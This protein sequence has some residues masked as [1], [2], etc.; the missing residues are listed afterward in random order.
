MFISGPCLTENL[1]EGLNV[2][3]SFVDLLLKIK[4]LRVVSL[5]SVPT[6]DPAEI[7]QKHKMTHCNKA[8]L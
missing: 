5:T 3:I 7:S 6:I 1:L 2:I 4:E 8:A